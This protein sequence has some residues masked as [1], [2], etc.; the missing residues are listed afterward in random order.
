M[1]RQGG[2]CLISA[3]GA[4]LTLLLSSVALAHDPTCAGLGG[5]E[6]HGQHVIG[7]YVTGVGGIGGGLDWPP[8]GGQ[9]GEAIAGE[10]AV[11]PGGPGPGFH[12]PNGF[13]PGASFCVEQAHPNGFTAPDT[14][15]NP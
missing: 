14:G 13:A 15:P 6:N 10:G 1:N 5:I 7:D 12:F 3:A 11:V 9:V 4:S 8:S 2:V